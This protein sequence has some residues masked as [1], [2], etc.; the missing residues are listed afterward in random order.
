[1]V[2]SSECCVLK[3]Q[4]I[5]WPLT[6]GGSWSWSLRDSHPL[7]PLLLLRVTV[8]YVRLYIGRLTARRRKVSKNPKFLWSHRRR[9][10]KLLP[11]SIFPWSS[12]SKETLES[13]NR[14]S[15]TNIRSRW[16]LRN[17]RSCIV[18]IRVHG[19]CQIVFGHSPIYIYIT[20]LLGLF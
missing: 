1:M 13:S 19:R 6:S 18:A 15:C 11:A 10:I 16:N 3:H 4:R 5:H 2:T 17:L 20:N 9:Y 12:T 14:R 8:F 7:Q